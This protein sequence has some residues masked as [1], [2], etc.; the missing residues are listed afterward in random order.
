[1]AKP[2]KTIS[3]QRKRNRKSKT[4]RMYSSRKPSGQPLASEPPLPPAIHHVHCPCELVM[5]WLWPEAKKPRLF[6]FGTKAKA[7]PKVWPGQIF[8][9]F[10]AKKARLA[11]L[12]AKANA[13]FGFGP[14]MAC[15]FRRPKPIKAGPKPWLSGQAKAKP[16]L[17]AN[18]YSDHRRPGN[19]TV[20]TVDVTW[21]NTKGLDG[22]TA[23]WVLP[24]RTAGWMDEPRRE[25]HATV[26]II[27]DALWT[28]RSN[29]VGN[30]AT[31]DSEVEDKL[32]KTE[33]VEIK[34]WLCVGALGFSEVEE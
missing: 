6:G 17:T 18:S 7:K 24:G 16:S 12:Q 21:Q 4:S 13:G 26:P 33:F 20:R 25:L 34:H 32:R 3:S 23:R 30:E 9:S 1:M 15:D 8:A 14:G 10:S 11:G 19:R 5:V 28:K 27:K 2:P 31:C 29:I 22:D